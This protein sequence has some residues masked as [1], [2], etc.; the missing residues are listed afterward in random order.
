MTWI[1]VGGLS[2]GA[3]LP[4]DTADYLPSRVVPQKKT[5]WGFSEVRASGI[6]SNYGTC[7]I[8]TGQT[9][10]QS[11]GTMVL[12]SGV[13]AR[14]ETIIRSTD[15]IDGAFTL[16]WSTV[17]SQ[18][19]ASQNYI[20]EL[21]DVIGDGLAYT[22]N[23]SSSITVTIPSN[24]F[25][26]VNVG[27]TVTIGNFAGTGTWLSGSAVIA[28]VSGNDVTFTVSSFAAG[29]GTCSIFGWNYYRVTYNGTAATNSTYQTQRNGWPGAAVSGT[30]LTTASPGHIFTLNHESG[31]ATVADQLRASSP[32]LQS[33]QRVNSVQDLPSNERQLR[34]Q[35]RSANGTPAPASTTTWTVAFVDYEMYVPQQTS[36]TS[37]RAQSHN[38]ALPVTVSSG[39]L[40][41]AGTVT[42]T[43]ASS[44]P[45][46][47]V[48][49]ASTN[50]A[51]V[52]ATAGALF[53]VSVSNVTATPIF[54]K[55]YNKATAPTVGTDVP[56]LTLPV[57]ANTTVAMEFGALGKRFSP[58]ISIAAT[59]AA[60]AADTAIAVAGVQINASYI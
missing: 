55:F 18:R 57:A 20:V 1:D 24:P 40:T 34:L 25:T 7:T 38:A 37:A 32:T 26:S 44:S 23:S 4:D 5:R 60:P 31:I 17:L 12:T 45:Y 42:S 10:S 48:T 8:G 52:K 16:R 21:V 58:G 51:N 9:V 53:E 35:I 29:T 11:G 14:S 33:T 41:S 50:A 19:I 30:F 47:V 36:I 43:P 46:N 27:Q 22:I 3:E 13:T 56:S 49:T 15:V 59:A 2:A 54:V 28:S 39:S 6:E